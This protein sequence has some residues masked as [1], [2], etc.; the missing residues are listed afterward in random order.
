MTALICGS[1]AFDTVMM[2]EGRFG[3]HILPDRIHQLNVSFL[4]PGMR[5]NFG[6]C[7]GNIAYNLKLLGDVGY[8]MAT[9]G[10]DFGLY[11]DWMRQTGVPAD[12]VRL[13]ETFA[14]VVSYFAVNISSPNTPGLREL[15]QAKVFDDLLARIMDARSRMSREAGTTPVLVKIAPDLSLSELDDLVGGARRHRVDG[16]IVGNTTVSRPTSNR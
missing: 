2:F 11:A 9:V 14:P 16:M 3:E 6:G 5:R 7:A 1:M 4:V 15:Q 10:R 13:I 12:Y 8:P